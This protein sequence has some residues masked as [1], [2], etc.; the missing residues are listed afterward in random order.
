MAGVKGMHNRQSRSP[1][2]AEAIRARIRAGGIAKLLEDHILGKRDMSKTQVAAAV[3]LLRL[4]IPQQASIEHS[5]EV[6]HSYVARMPEVANTTEQ[7]QQQYS[8]AT[9]TRQ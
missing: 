7:W 2:Y 5:G 8:P 9:L 4:V 3:A 1:Y 6:K